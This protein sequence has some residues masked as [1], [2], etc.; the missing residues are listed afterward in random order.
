MSFFSLSEMHRNLCLTA[1]SHT[2]AGFKEKEASRRQAK[3]RRR[4]EEGVEEEKEASILN[5]E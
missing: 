5:G 1:L 2:A 3:A 4:G